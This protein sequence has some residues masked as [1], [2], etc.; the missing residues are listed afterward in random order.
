[1]ASK[2]DRRKFMAQSLL[3]M[4]GMA[5]V[6]SLEERSVLAALQE[7]GSVTPDAEAEAAREPMPYGQIGD[8][9]ISRLILGSNLIGGYAHS[10]DLLYVSKLFHAY[11]TDQKILDTFELAEQLGVNS[12]LTSPPS[13]KSIPRRILQRPRTKWIRQS[14]REL[15][16][17]PRM[18]EE[19]TSWCVTA[20]W[21]RYCRRWNWSSGTAFPPGS[22]VTR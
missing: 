6:S 14:T 21:N 4:S 18:A 9:K 5:A 13:L 16:P 10:R 17:Y 15:A 12:I 11:N 1:M 2:S 3:G 7:G 20:N 8:V 19:P 22:V